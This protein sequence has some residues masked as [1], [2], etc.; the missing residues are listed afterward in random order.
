[1]TLAGAGL[2]G[3]LHLFRTPA[4]IVTFML[5]F[6]GVPAVAWAVYRY[7]LS[8]DARTWWRL[9]SVRRRRIYDAVGRGR[10]RLVGRVRV[11]GAPLIA[12]VSGRA[13]VAYSFR[14]EERSQGRDL[15]G[16][17]NE[18]WSEIARFE[19]IRDFVL[20]DESGAALVD[21]VGARLLLAE[22]IL[23]DVTRGDQPP[24]ALE[25]LVRRLGH[26]VLQEFPGR[27]PAARPLR[28]LEGV[29][30]EGETAA[31]T[32]SPIMVM[33]GGGSAPAG[34]DGRP[35]PY[36]VTAGLDD[37]VL[38]SNVPTAAS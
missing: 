6:F 16:R 11:A 38:V 14:A 15:S 19:E 30:V 2:A 10:A 8:R 35:L 18:Y 27:P 29:L 28:F 34:P 37:Q 26:D 12:P 33:P 9:R 7:F 23:V 32:G 31:V 5:V 4:E 13:C 17:P 36:Q 25:E 22:D 3:P 1:V 20:E 21:T 24:V